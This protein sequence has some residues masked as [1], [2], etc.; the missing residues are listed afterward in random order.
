MTRQKRHSA[1]IP[2]RSLRVADQIQR[3]LAELLQLEVKDPRIGMVTLTGVE[4]SPDYSHA[5]VYFSTLAENAKI[6]DVEQGLNAARGFL[7]RAVAAHRY[8][9]ERHRQGLSAHEL[10][11]LHARTSAR[12]APGCAWRIAAG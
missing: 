9:V 3:D 8:S 11:G 2:G 1:A 4:V 12:G 6:H 7:R 10:T 5:K